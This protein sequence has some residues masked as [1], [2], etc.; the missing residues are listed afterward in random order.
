MM[1]ETILYVWDVYIAL[2]YICFVQWHY[3][4]THTQIQTHRNIHTYIHVY[5]VNVKNIY[6]PPPTFVWVCIFDIFVV[7]VIDEIIINYL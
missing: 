6:D 2:N 4:W 5:N 3:I 7:V 1:T